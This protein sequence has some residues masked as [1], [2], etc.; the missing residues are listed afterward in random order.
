MLSLVDHLLEMLDV[1][2]VFFPALPDKCE[3]WSVNN[4]N[5]HE[6]EIKFPRKKETNKEQTQPKNKQHPHPNQA[7]DQAD[8]PGK[9]AN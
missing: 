9:F 3:T 8:L 2:D 7:P 5:L 4:W 6:I 1:S